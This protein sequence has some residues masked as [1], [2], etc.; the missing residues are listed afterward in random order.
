[1]ATALTHVFVALQRPAGY[2]DVH[3]E[4]VVEDALRHNSSWPHEIVRDDGGSVVVALER[5]EGYEAVSADE[6]AQEAINQTWP[7]WHI[8]PG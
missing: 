6:L 5:L 2:E 8:V 1:M 4:F 3:P 7:D